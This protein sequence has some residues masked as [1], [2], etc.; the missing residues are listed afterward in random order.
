M[1]S[2]SIVTH[3]ARVATFCV[4]NVATVATFCVLN[5]ATV[6]TFNLFFK[7]VL[8]FKYVIYCCKCVNS[9]ISYTHKPMFYADVFAESK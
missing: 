1:R 4:L 3:T 6:A 2:F 5:V 7:G 8:S 9:K